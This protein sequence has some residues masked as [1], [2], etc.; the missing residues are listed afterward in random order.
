MSSS[1]GGQPAILDSGFWSV[2]T[3]PARDVALPAAHSG[4]L[5][6]GILL[7]VSPPM[8]SAFWDSGILPAVTAAFLDSGFCDSAMV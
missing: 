5:D 1:G 6:S 7:S 2:H 3:L 4:F 8:D